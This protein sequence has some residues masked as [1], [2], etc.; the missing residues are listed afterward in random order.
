VQL[1][2]NKRHQRRSA[3]FNCEISPV[4]RL[5][6]AH[7]K[8]RPRAFSK[9]IKAQGVDHLIRSRPALASLWWCSAVVPRGYR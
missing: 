1:A 8:P 7:A 4:E 3:L 2:Q 9:I 6:Q 5:A